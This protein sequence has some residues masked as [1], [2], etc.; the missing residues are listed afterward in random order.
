MG[1]IGKVNSALFN[2][3]KMYSIMLNVYR[4]VAV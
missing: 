1:D 2:L 3:N 4:P